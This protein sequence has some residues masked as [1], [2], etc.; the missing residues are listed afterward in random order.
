MKKTECVLWYRPVEMWWHTRVETRFRLSAKLTSPF[1]S[2]G[3][4]GALVQSTTGSRGVRVSVSSAGYTMLRGS[5]KSTGYPLH[6]P[7]SPFTSPPVRH[8]VPSHFSW[9]LDAQWPSVC[10]TPCIP[11][12]VI[13][14]NMPSCID[15]L[16]LEENFGIIVSRMVS[17]PSEIFP[18]TKIS[19]ALCDTQ[20]SG[21]REFLSYLERCW[22]IK[23]Q[24]C[25]SYKFTFQ[26]EPIRPAS[27]SSDQ[28]LWLL[29]MRSRVRFPVLP[30]EFFLAGKYSLGDHGLG[31][32]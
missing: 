19:V 6:S 21:A 24:I 29:I 8:R 12:T 30:W 7:V 28:G 25:K 13:I 18:R 16:F 14:W 32:Q 5:V 9:T 15:L 17:N 1:K 26:L 11:R 31:S 3:G 10:L 27:W 22:I 20:V 2:A 23:D 4:G